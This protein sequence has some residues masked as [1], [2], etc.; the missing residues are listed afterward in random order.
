MIIYLQGAKPMKKQQPAR[1]NN[2]Q[3]EKIRK[4]RIFC[5]ETIKMLEGIG[6]TKEVQ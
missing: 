3:Y 2:I 5:E 6:G 1:T 4:N